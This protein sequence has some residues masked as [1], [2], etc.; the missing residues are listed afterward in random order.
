MQVEIENDENGNR[1]VAQ[2]ASFFVKKTHKILNS[3]DAM[4]NTLNVFPIG[5]ES[6]S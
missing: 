4:F 3:C 1:L 6:M 2:L 5:R